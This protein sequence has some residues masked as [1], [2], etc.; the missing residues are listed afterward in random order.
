MGTVNQAFGGAR[1]DVF[2]D[3][4]SRSMLFTFL[5]LIFCAVFF[6]LHDV[7]GKQSVFDSASSVWRVLS[8][9]LYENAASPRLYIHTRNV[10][11]LYPGKTQLN[12][13]H[14]GAYLSIAGISGIC[15]ILFACL[16]QI[17]C[18]ADWVRKKIA[19][20]RA[21]LKWY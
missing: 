9:A 7:P 21:L 16:L 4:V 2:D 8:H 13:I 3:F 17:L 11:G 1:P 18:F 6:S 14:Q 20:R 5:G 19:G 12:L 10:A 15:N